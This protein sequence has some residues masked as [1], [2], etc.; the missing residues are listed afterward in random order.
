MINVKHLTLSFLIINLI[1]VSS[2]HDILLNKVKADDEAIN[3]CE[4]ISDFDTTFS[5][6]IITLQNEEFTP[7]LFDTYYEAIKTQI[8]FCQNAY[9][10]NQAGEEYDKIFEADFIYEEGDSIMDAITKTQEID[11]RKRIIEQEISEET[12]FFTKTKLTIDTMYT[13][14][15]EGLFE[16][17]NN[18][19]KLEATVNSDLQSSQSVNNSIP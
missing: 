8:Q 10:T 17:L 19:T 11:R 9:F 13:P 12:E 18:L 1:L 14:I 5:E 3:I 15:Y 7:E 4:N 2:S 6:Q 16:L